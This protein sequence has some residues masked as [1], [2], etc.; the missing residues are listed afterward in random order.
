MEFDNNMDNSSR[1]H[2]D[3]MQISLNDVKIK[4]IGKSSIES[5]GNNLIINSYDS[6]FNFINSMDNIDFLIFSKGNFFNDDKVFIGIDGK[7]FELT[8]KNNENALHN[9]YDNL[10]KIKGFG[11]RSK[12]YV[13]LDTFNSNYNRKLSDNKVSKYISDNVDS[14]KQLDSDDSQKQLASVEIR[15]FYNLMKEGIITEEEFE[16]KKKELLKLI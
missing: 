5:S 9:F 3:N 16:E 11:I 4:G 8:C 7:Q 2:T 14:D 13:G 1:S 15:N 6:N 12:E 10:V